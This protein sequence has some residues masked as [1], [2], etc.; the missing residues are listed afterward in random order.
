MRIINLQLSQTWTKSPW[1]ALDINYSPETVIRRYKTKVLVEDVG[2]KTNVMVV[3]TSR[4]QG[5]LRV[6]DKVGRSMIGKR[7]VLKV[8]HASRE[9]V[10]S[11]DDWQ[12]CSLQPESLTLWPQD[13]VFLHFATCL[14]EDVFSSL[15]AG[16]TPR[17]QVYSSW[18]ITEFTY[19]PRLAKSCGASKL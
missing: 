19:T 9:Y 18:R 16:L 1:N 13:F 11:T 6:F 5:C 15:N 17:W 2:T 14:A 12:H 8:C 4:W 7:W 3:E 10:L